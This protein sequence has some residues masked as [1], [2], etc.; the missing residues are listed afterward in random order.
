MRRG[1]SLAKLV[2]TLVLCGAGFYVLVVA[3]DPWSIHMGG[4]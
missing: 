2:L 1:G 3:L 4:R